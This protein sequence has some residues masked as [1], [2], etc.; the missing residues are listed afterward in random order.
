MHQ[1]NFGFLFPLFFFKDYTF[2]ETVRAGA[3]ERRRHSAR[4]CQ[5]LAKDAKT[6]QGKAV[7]K[8]ATCKADAKAPWE[9]P[10]NWKP[11]TPDGVSVANKGIPM[12]NKG[13]VRADRWCVLPKKAQ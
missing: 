11:L 5:H 10:K 9:V 12:S 7:K 13:N 2:F 6:K 3:M 4:A 8:K 1:H